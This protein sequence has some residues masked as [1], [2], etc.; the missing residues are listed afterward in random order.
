VIVNEVITS[1]TISQSQVICTGT[2]PAK[3]TGTMPAGGNGSYTYYWEAAGAD[4]VFRK[5]NNS[6]TAELAPGVLTSTTS[7]R[8]VVESGPCAHVSNTVTITVSPAITS[9]TV[10]LK[11]S[12]YAG[13]TP[14]PLTGSLPAGGAGPDTYTYVW[15]SSDSQHS[16]YQP[17]AG[18]N[19]NRH[20][21][22]QAQQE[23]TWFRRR[24]L[25]G[26]CESVSE[27]VLID[28]LKGVTNNNIRTDQ[29]I[30]AGNKPATLNGSQP[31]GGNGQY[32]YLWLASTKGAKTGFVTASGSS[33]SQ[34]YSPAA[35]TQSTWFRRV[36]VSGPNQDTSAAVQISVK[37]PMANNKI[38]TSQTICYGTAP[39][40]LT[41][42]LPTGGSGS[43][44]YLWESSTSGPDKGY[45]TASGTNNR[46]EYSPAALTQ[47]TWFRRV[48]TSE[49]CDRLVSDAVMMTV[50]PLPATPVASGLTI[51]PGTST[52]LTATGKGG[53]LEWYTAPTGGNPVKVG[54][55]FTTPTLSSTT[56]YYVQE[57]ALSCA[58]ERRAVTVTV[59]PPSANAGLDVTT[60][61]GRTV[62][63]QASGGTTYTWSPALG[64]SDPNIANPL[65]NPE[66]TT[67][68]TVT[69]TTAAGCVSTAQVTVTVQELVY[70]PN[71][72]TPNRDG[73][74]DTWEILNIEQYPN[75]KVQI[76]N[77]WGN[78]VFT[79]DGYKQQWDGSYKGQELPLATYYYIIQLDNKE[80]PLSGSVTIVK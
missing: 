60:I 14:A 74:N 26:G 11:Q 54:D 24:V 78:L 25:S 72:F 21:S 52:T 79:S 23:P 4:G 18:V 61:K 55:S 51:C 30:C 13:Q 58:S 43:Y 22:P 68:Y 63:L 45:M 48:V 80:K 47:T 46:Q 44:T 31:E 62:Q 53:R 17:A 29:V 9:N 41:G 16:G 5:V 49:S 50:T 42:T 64:L 34:D 7:Y 8:R 1:N 70:V 66:V 67:T 35:L 27:P 20:Y 69:A 33:T 76:F 73:I 28:V 3:L 57:V 75:C 15:E 38:S 12:I 65:A 32:Q 19:G 10:G 59:T 56:T 40:V 6:Q 37:P 36:V 39:S 71:T 77:Q 2:A